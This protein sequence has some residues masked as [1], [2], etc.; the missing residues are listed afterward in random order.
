M[1]PQR[2]PAKSETRDAHVQH[3]LRTLVSIESRLDADLSLEA[4][5]RVA[6]FSQFHFQ[7]VFRQ[8]A[9]LSPAA[10]V[11]RL[12]LDRAAR[13]L[14]YGR[15]PVAAIARRAGFADVAPFYRAFRARFGETPAAFRA[16]RRSAPRLPMPSCVRAWVNAP[17]EDGQ[18]RYVPVAARSPSA[19]SRPAWRIVELPPLRLAFVRMPADA[20]DGEVFRTLGSFAALRAPSEDLC[21]MR[22]LHDDDDLT[23]ASD[24]R[25]DRCVVC[26]PRRR[27][28][29]AVG[30]RFA[31]GGDYVVATAEGDRAATRRTRQWLERSVLP[32]L[33]CSRRDGPAIEIVLDDPRDATIPEDARLSD[34][35]VPIAESRSRGH[36]YWRRRRPPQQKR[37]K[38]GRRG[39]LS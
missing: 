36:W 8:V 4:L 29:G 15:K 5:A 34:V 14:A 3:V 16:A 28:Q 6:N 22:L 37:G 31:G 19:G 13:D 26:G 24:L 17:L 2:R 9:G 33:G 23:A 21:F 18:L 39:E 20:R 1:A 30:A 7:R 11:R 38:S 32:Q 10:F 27:P 12:R 25:L 35:L